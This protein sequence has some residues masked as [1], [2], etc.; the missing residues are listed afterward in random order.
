MATKLFII[1]RNDVKVSKQQIAEL[2]SFHISQFFIENNNLDIMLDGAI[3][4]AV[5]P[6]ERG[7]IREGMQVELRTVQSHYALE[8]L[9]LN[10]EINGLP[11]SEKYK[12]RP[13]EFDDLEELSLSVGPCEPKLVGEIIK[14]TKQLR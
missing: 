1:L 11:M 14:K 4:L 3:E 7:W 6:E 5:S 13:T 8:T 9:R 12:T 2:T 10:M